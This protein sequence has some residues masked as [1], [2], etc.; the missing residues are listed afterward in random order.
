MNYECDLTV[1]GS[2]YQTFGQKFQ[3]Y[4]L[5]S[6]SMNSQG[7]KLSPQLIFVY[8]LECQLEY[9]LQ[10][11][12]ELAHIFNR[13]E[14]V[15]IWKIPVQHHKLERSNS[16]ELDIHVH[17]SIP[18]FK[19]NHSMSTIRQLHVCTWHS[20]ADAVRHIIPCFSVS[21]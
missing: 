17:H 1:I 4:L 15:S 3:R 6:K 10:N 13:I 9:L 18:I 7:Y 2:F 21:E 14:K 20:S 12:W 11:S 16:F 5:L 8:K 19:K